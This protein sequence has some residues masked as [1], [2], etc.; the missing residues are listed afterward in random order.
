MFGLQPL[1][2]SDSY[3]FAHASK[4]YYVSTDMLGD[5]WEGGQFHVTI[6]RFP[7]V[8]LELFYPTKAAYV[9]QKP[10][11][12]AAVL[13]DYL[14]L[15]SQGFG[16]SIPSDVH[17]GCVFSARK[18]ILPYHKG[19]VL[20]PLHVNGGVTWAAMNMILVYR[21]EEWEKVLLHELLHYFGFDYFPQGL[22]E[23]DSQ[24]AKQ[25]SIE[26]STPRG[27]GLNEAYIEALTSIIYVAYIVLCG[28]SRS[29]AFTTFK[30]LW[31]SAMRFTQ[32]HYIKQIVKLQT[33]Y[34]KLAW[35]ESTHVFSYYVCK[36][37]LLHNLDAFLKWLRQ[38]G[39]RICMKQ[40]LKTIASYEHFLYN[41]LQN[42]RFWKS[43]ELNKNEMTG[44][45]QNRKDSSL[46]MLLLDTKCSKVI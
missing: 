41:C 8:S 12:V 28:R 31:R 35:R 5:S 38:L 25:F 45:K 9:R 16:I 13:A 6:E 23:V 27:L 10:S 3:I 44:V 21:E 20:T 18:R 34:G 32:N 22:M 11:K 43:V 39:P 17:I 46:R 42:S 37:C 36:A 29:S 15:F 24:I 19:A 1:L 4:L 40:D 30:S 14:D 33:H 2:S 26:A 7:N